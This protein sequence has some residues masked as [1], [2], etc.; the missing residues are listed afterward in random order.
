MLYWS[1]LKKK[2]FYHVISSRINVCFSWKQDEKNKLIEDLN[3]VIFLWL[4]GIEDFLYVLWDR[5][6][7]LTTRLFYNPFFFR[8][9][10][11]FVFHLFS[12]FFCITKSQI[13]YK[14]FAF[15]IIPEFKFTIHCGHW[16]STY[17][18]EEC[19]SLCTLSPS[20]ICACGFWEKF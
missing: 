10:Y 6:I 20:F 11:T 19:I 18:L 15:G 2:I 8:F 5:T 3:K 4:N 16:Y 1:R 9:L 13:C 12:N 14:K 7:F 17:M